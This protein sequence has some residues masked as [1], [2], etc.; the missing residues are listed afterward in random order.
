MHD[1]I[2][3]TIE[4]NTIY[5]SAEN[6]GHIEMTNI[7]DSINLTNSKSLIIN[8]Y[9]GFML[10]LPQAGEVRTFD[11]FVENGGTLTLNEEGN[12]INAYNSGGDP[13]PFVE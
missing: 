8:V 10:P 4:I 2:N 9:D 7:G 3:G 5:N 11:L 6:N 13:N 12:V 1:D